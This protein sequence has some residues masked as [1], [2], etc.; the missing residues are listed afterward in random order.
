MNPLS[1]NPRKADKERMAS[2]PADVGVALSV[3]TFHM[4]KNGIGSG[5]QDDKGVVLFPPA[6]WSSSCHKYVGGASVVGSV[7]AGV[8]R[9][10]GRGNTL[11]CTLKDEPENRGHNVATVIGWSFTTPH[12]FMFL[13]CSTL[14][15]NLHSLYSLVPLCHLFSIFL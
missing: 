5:D 8:G 6:W 4:V 11:S 15:S 12:V 13:L 10:F 14:F 2:K 9:R 3:R 7:W 1:R